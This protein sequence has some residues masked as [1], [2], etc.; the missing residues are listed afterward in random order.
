MRLSLPTIAN[1][2]RALFPFAFGVVDKVTSPVTA[3]FAG[4]RHLVDYGRQ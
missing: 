2:T 4:T 3:R 1:F